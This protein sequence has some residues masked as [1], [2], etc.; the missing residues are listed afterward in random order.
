M[1]LEERLK[2]DYIRI[3]LPDMQARF[4][5]NRSTMDNIYILNYVIEKEISKKGEKNLSHFK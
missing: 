2:Q 3:R 4:R 1:L 5:K